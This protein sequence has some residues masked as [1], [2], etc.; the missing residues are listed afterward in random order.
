MF[1]NRWFRVKNRPSQS[2]RSRAAAKPR[3]RTRL[4]VEEFEA[5]VTPSCSGSVSSR[6]LTVNCDSSVNT[7]NYDDNGI[8]TNVNGV[9]ISDSLF[10]SFQINIGTGGGTVNLL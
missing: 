8:S 10:D 2:V 1:R 7:V 6:V 4:H 9:I 3:P 5:R